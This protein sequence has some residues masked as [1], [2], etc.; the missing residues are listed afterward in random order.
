MA[1]R[2][3]LEGLAGGDE[4][5]APVAETGVGA[6]FEAAANQ[7]IGILT[8]QESVPDTLPF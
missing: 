2:F 1:E 7:G 3:A 5:G 6:V 8:L 4:A